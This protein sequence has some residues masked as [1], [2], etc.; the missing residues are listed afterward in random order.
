MKPS[1]LNAEI[2]RIRK[3]YERRSKQMPENYYSAENPANRFIYVRRLQTAQKFLEKGKKFPLQ[4][5]KIL[6]IGCGSGGWLPAFE[7]WSANQSCLHG[8]DLDESRIAEA[9]QLLPKAELRV[10]EASRLPWPSRYFDIVLQ[11]TVFSSILMP[12]LRQAIAG[13]MMR[14]LKPG[15]MILWYDFF[16]DNPWNPNV[17]SVKAGEIQRLFTHCRIKLERITLAPP[18]LRA[19]APRFDSLCVFLER[20]KFL[21]T[22]YFAC[23]VP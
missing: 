18:L 3:E 7:K 5:N 23:I 2:D 12:E 20:L 21:N 11:S 8:I 13:E 1:E 15:G 6:E 10:G 22:H 9:R 17:R 14:V 19:L 16:W 4:E